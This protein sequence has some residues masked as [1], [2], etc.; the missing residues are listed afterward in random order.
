MHLDS[1]FLFLSGTLV[2]DVIRNI[3]M[4]VQSASQFLLDQSAKVGKKPTV[5]YV[6]IRHTHTYTHTHVDLHM[7][8]EFG[9]SRCK[10]VCIGG[11]DKKSLLYSTGNFIKYPVMKHNGKNMKKNVCVCVC[12]CV[13]N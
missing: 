3:N 11:I 5:L 12:V 2:C 4:W 6:R 7:N 1:W 8:W 9:T 10:L 13:C